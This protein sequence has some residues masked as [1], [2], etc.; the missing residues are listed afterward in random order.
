MER[1][2]A[3]LVKDFEAGKITRRQF[4]EA[5]AIAAVVCGYGTGAKAAPAK[6][7]KM[8]G[9]NHI[10]YSCADYT[11][12]R[13]WY[14]SNLGMQVLNVNKKNRANLAF[15]PEPEKVRRRTVQTRRKYESMPEKDMQKELKQLEKAMFD[16]AK[17]LEFEKAAQLRDQLHDLSHGALHVLGVWSRLPGAEVARLELTLA[18]GARVNVSEVEGGLELHVSGP[19]T[20]AQATAPAMQ[21]TGAASRISEISVAHT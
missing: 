16:A 11:K 8:L 19:A 14:S 20:A 3:G 4:G 2:I 18:P 21:R 1:F 17:N 10:S 13:D 12:V 9:V 7:L 6:G 5:V 15:G